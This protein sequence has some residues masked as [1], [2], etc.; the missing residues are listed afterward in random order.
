MVIMQKLRGY[1]QVA[2]IL[3]LELA[4]I[5]LLHQLGH[6]SEL[7]IPWNDLSAWFSS[8][9][10]QTLIAASARLL[11][12]VIAYYL[13]VTTLLYTIASL[14]KM[15]GFV[16]ILR[17]V[18]LPAVRNSLDKALAA[19][20][21]TV[22]IV[23]GSA[24]FA[25]ADVSIPF[26]PGV[27]QT[28]PQQDTTSTT[29]TQTTSGDSGDFFPPEE[30]TTTTTEAPPTTTSTTQVTIPGLGETTV[31]TTPSTT[32]TT[33]PSSPS[34]ETPAPQEPTTAVEGE[35]IYKVV[36]GDN[37]WSISKKHLAEAQGVDASTLSDHD[38]A[39]YWLKVIEVN[40]DNLRSGNPNLIYPDEQ[41]TLPDI[42]VA[43]S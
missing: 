41:I 29:S 16:R 13:F 5:V 10:L 7:H 1:A 19:T 42:S 8:S 25:A 17:F 39:K 15:K 28:V 27:V 22:S 6:S 43:G 21:L 26:P 32:S 36:P 24:T 37:L 31:T 35:Q 11:G 38:V 4:A 34:T 2:A 20:A 23:G 30:S 33:T 14:L 3:G 12:L 40:K 9:Q 18:T